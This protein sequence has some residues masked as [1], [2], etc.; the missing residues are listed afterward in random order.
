MSKLVLSIV[1]LFALATPSYAEE[2]ISTTEV[3]A[4][5]EAALDATIGKHRVAVRLVTSPAPPWWP[6]WLT[7]GGW[8]PGQPSSHLSELSVKVDGKELHVPRDAFEPLFVVHGAHLTPS[9]DGFV[10]TVYGSE[11]AEVYS[12]DFTFDFEVMG[13]R[14]FLLSMPT[15]YGQE[16]RRVY[17][18]GMWQCEREAKVSGSVC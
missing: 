9:R 15:G 11:N 1:L 2:P 18:D 14:E 13:L 5:G 7:V 10:L 4:A 17:D 3:P 12:A 16:E 6:E 8:S